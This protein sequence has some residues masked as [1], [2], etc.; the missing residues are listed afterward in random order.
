MTV[1][2]TF[3]IVD[4]M[5]YEMKTLNIFY[6]NVR[7]FIK[8]EY[9]IEEKRYTA[10]QTPTYLVNQYTL[11]FVYAYNDG[12]RYY[13]N[14]VNQIHEWLV[15]NQLHHFHTVSTFFQQDLKR[16]YKQLLAL[17]AFT[18]LIIFLALRALLRWICCKKVQ[19]AP[20]VKEVKNNKI[21]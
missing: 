11:Y 21:D 7:S 17:G 14:N 5:C 16:Q 9:L 1:P 20:A 3:Y 15:S 18:I 12:L 8:G 13:N 19:E 6:D 2:Q 4:G 10:F